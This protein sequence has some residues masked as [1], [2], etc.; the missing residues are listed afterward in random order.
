MGI[1]KHISKV[2]QIKAQDVVSGLGDPIKLAER[3]VYDLKKDLLRI[4]SLL[5]EVRGKRIYLLRSI[6]SKK[7]LFERLSDE[8]MELGVEI[9]RLVQRAD[10]YKQMANQL[11]VNIEN[12][13]STIAKCENKLIDLRTRTRTAVAIKKVSQQ[14]MHKNLLSMDNIEKICTEV[15]EEEALATA[16]NEV[17]AEMK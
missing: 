16:Y 13:K 3:D 5:A 12:V 6:A 8:D 17:T 11:E 9:A 4:M 10:H 2:C 14:L 7:E 1:L 15:E